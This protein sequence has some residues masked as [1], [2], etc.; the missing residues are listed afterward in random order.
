MVASSGEVDAVLAVG[1]LGYWSARFPQFEDLV[2]AELNGAAAMARAA[3]DAGKPLVV[4]TVYPDSAPAAALR[5][6][7]VPVYREI[8]S[9]AA[10][11]A[12][13]AGA[14][15]RPGGVP[16]LPRPSPPV[17]ASCGYLEARALLREAGLPFPAARR[18]GT[19]EEAV[20][21]ARAVGFPVVLKALGILHKSD[22]GGV[23]LG[24]GD[25]AAVAA[26]WRSMTERLRPPGLA[27]EREVE[28][29]GAV[30]L[31][32]GCRRDPRFGPVALVGLGGV[33]AEVLSD[34]RTALAPVTPDEARRCCA[35]FAARPCWTAPVGGR[36]STARRRRG[37]WPTCR[38]SRPPTPRSAR[39]R[40]TRCWCRPMA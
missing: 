34:V 39:S 5:A 28:R 22:A 25:E 11:L 8:A 21:A 31:I 23:A 27:V 4:S 1:Q 37:R 15:G 35:S 19:C 24:L 40:S 26:A 38:G 16:D 6:E 32:I 13:L 36:R 12:A 9:A 3:R 20:A 2:Q 14:G 10:A 7:G 30:E 17:T 18:V 33:Y 29:S